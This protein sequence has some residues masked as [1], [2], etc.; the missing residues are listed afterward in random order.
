MGDDEMEGAFM[1]RLS[2]VAA[3]V[4]VRPAALTLANN[5][6]ARGARRLR[7]RV[8]GRGARGGGRRHR[9]P[10]L[11]RE[12][13][14]TRRRHSPAV[15]ASAPGLAALLCLQGRARRL[16]R[17]SARCCDAATDTRPCTGA[18]ALCARSADPARCPPGASPARVGGPQGRAGRLRG[19][20]RYGKGAGGVVRAAARAASRVT[21]RTHSCAHRAHALPRCAGASK[22]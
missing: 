7:L 4:A 9:E 6:R 17:L 14:A 21:Q 18:A 19:R 20:H 3:R 10:V 22:R 13:R 2:G 1:R 12:R 16:L 8:L 15:V 11:Q 5:S